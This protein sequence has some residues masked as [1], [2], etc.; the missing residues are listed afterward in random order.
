MSPLAVTALVVAGVLV[1][2]LVVSCLLRANRLDRLHVRTDAARA[3]LAAALDRRAVVARAVALH[4]GDDGLLRVAARAEAAPAAEREFRENDLGR[5]LA[6]LD[7]RR[8]AGA[9]VAEL[10]DAE[11]RLMLARR[12]H[13]DAVRDTLALRSRRLVR[14]LRLAGTA[15]VPEYFE[16]TDEQPEPEDTAVV[17]PS[18]RR[19]G[20]VVLLD[21]DGRV[22]LFEGFDPARPQESFWFTPGGG[23]Q[24]GEDTRGAAVRELAE[25]TGLRLPGEALV[26]P[27]WRRHTVFNF[28]GDSLA[29]DEEFFLAPPE[30]E[31]DGAVDTSGFNE[32]ERA[33]VL[34]HRWWSAAELRGTDA[35]VYPRQLGALLEQLGSG[36][37]DGV[38]R[39]IS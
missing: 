9:L 7:R 14:W 1:A 25:E 33:T 16:I 28:A 15:P 24:T 19:S 27:V 39:P 6:G 17:P 18:V 10:V 31:L 8:L 35:V 5:L 13:N 20:R 30:V 3:A 36:R 12:V 22:L 38:T 32:L 21:T 29:A 34:G 11:Q 26:G 23:L 2:L 37:W 4:V